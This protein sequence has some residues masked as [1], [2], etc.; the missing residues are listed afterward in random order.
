[1]PTQSQLNHTRL[2]LTAQGEPKKSWHTREG[3]EDNAR[4]IKR[5]TKDKLTAYHCPY[6]ERWHIGHTR[7]KR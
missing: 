7:S 5:K 3:A 1:M 2:H 6:C 4:R